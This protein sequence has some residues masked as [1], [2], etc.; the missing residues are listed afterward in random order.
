MQGIQQHIV[1]LSMYCTDHE[2]EFYMSDLYSL[3]AT[4]EES[5]WLIFE[6]R[7]LA[8]MYNGGPR[9]GNVQPQRLTLFMYTCSLPGLPCPDSIKMIGVEVCP[10]CKEPGQMWETIIQSTSVQFYSAAPPITLNWT[11]CGDLTLLA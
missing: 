7:Q 4:D 5:W 2:A 11:M 3:A 10:Q 8:V 1:H 9:P 6:G